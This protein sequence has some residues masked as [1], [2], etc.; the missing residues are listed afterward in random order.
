LLDLTGLAYPAA[1]SER[2]STLRLDIGSRA[3]IVRDVDGIPHVLAR[4]ETDMAYLQGYVHARDRLF[5]MEVSRRMAEG[6]LAELLGQPALSSDV[7]MRTIGL[8]RAA[9]RS[10]AVQSPELRAVLTAYAAGVNAW[11]S[12]NPLPPEYGPLEVTR[13]RPWTDVDSLTVFKL[14][15]LPLIAFDDIDR[16][17]RFEEYRAAGA[18]QG[19]DGT[20]L[21]FG[22]VERSAP[23]E[24]A[25]VIPDALQKNPA[26]HDHRGWRN[27]H[28]PRLDAATSTLA[29]GLTDRLRSAPFAASLLFPQEQGDR[30]SNAWMRSG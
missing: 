18:A 13:F 23:F 16:T 24:P 10:L 21:F 3:Q 8:R 26:R 27:Q 28:A 25:S 5:Q 12:A 4:S 15:L 14:A 17:A 2:T 6:T 30:G 29:R 22:D 11:V 19:F 9:E 1:T 20:A 7:Q